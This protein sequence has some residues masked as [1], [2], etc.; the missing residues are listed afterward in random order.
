MMSPFPDN[1]DG[2]LLN[3][4]DRPAAPP[5]AYGLKG[6]AIDADGNPRRSHATPKAIDCRQ[7]GH[8]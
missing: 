1:I 3:N 6:F 2:A 7:S 4:P 8:R 5:L